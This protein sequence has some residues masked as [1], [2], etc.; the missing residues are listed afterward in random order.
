[1]VVARAGDPEARPGRPTHTPSVP[2]EILSDSCSP[3]VLVEVRA[4]PPV[5]PGVC[6]RY[7][8]ARRP[9]RDSWRGKG[10]RD[11]HVRVASELTRQRHRRVQRLDPARCL[12]R[13][14]WPGS[15]AAG[16]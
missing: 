8:G 13:P 14:S 2:K 4:S 10:D 12:A 16:W 5:D 15:T 6:R 9:P 7:T 11:G 3:P 1:M